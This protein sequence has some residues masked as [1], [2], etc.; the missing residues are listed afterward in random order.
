MKFVDEV[1]IPVVTMALTN[2]CVSSTAAAKKCISRLGS[3]GWR[4]QLVIWCDGYGWK[5]TN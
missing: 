3:P 4:Q 2:G 1:S 5:P